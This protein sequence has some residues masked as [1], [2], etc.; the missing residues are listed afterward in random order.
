[1]VVVVGVGAEEAVVAGRSL[2]S[3]IRGESMS[4]CARLPPACDAPRTV[5]ECEL[6]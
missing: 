2:W 3:G 6:P 5:S 4:C 1:M